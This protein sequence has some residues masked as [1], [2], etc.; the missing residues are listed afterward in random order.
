MAFDFR[1]LSEEF[2]IYVGTSFNDA[3]IAEL[4]NSTWTTSGSADHRTEQLR[5]RRLG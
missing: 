2:P 4:D 3:F 5:L 1:F